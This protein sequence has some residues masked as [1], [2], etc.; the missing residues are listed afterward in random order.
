MKQAYSQKFLGFKKFQFFKKFRFLSVVRGNLNL[1][2]SQNL[3]RFDVY[4]NDRLNNHLAFFFKTFEFNSGLFFK[5]LRDVG[6]SE[7]SYVTLFGDNRIKSLAWLSIL[8]DY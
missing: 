7:L 1:Q 3:L 4:N 2:K 5:K 6:Y 8:S